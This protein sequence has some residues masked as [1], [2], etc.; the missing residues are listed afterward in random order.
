MKRFAYTLSE[1]LITLCIIG[2]VSAMVTP[3]VTNIM[4][5]KK[6]A[7]VLKKYAELSK[8][9]QQV[10]N[11]RRYY[12]QDI[13]NPDDQCLGIACTNT[14][15][16]ANVPD[17]TGDWTGRNKY[18]FIMEHLLGGTRGAFL[19]N[20]RLIFSTD[21]GV[22]YNIA[23]T[24]NRTQRVNIYGGNTFTTS[25]TVTII[26]PADCYD[27]SVGVY[28]AQNQNPLSFSFN[29]DTYGNITGADP[30][31]RAYLMNPDKLNNKAKDLQQANRFIQ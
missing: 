28:S 8:L 31:T 19:P 15:L 17:A 16:G 21:D 1:V 30:L 5:D 22:I 12:F 18:G 26:L 6:K 13:N 4:P 29:V 24:Q 9:T 23:A 2:I 20:T 25:T 11:D 27:G 7:V 14:V 10:L 3:A